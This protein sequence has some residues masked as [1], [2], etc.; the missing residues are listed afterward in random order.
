VFLE[1]LRCRAVQIGDWEK[2]IRAAI[3]LYEELAQA[4]TKFPSS[5]GRAEAGRGKCA[6]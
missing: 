6:G 1:G 2:A 5:G 3:H 4:L